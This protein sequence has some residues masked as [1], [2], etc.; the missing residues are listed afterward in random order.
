MIN[1][2]LLCFPLSVV[3]QTYP[4]NDPNRLSASR[5]ARK[6]LPS[7]DPILSRGSSSSRLNDADLALQNLARL[8]ISS[9][10]D[11]FMQYCKFWNCM[12]M[13]V[14]YS[15]CLWSLHVFT[16]TLLYVCIVTAP[17]NWSKGK[18]LGSG[19]FGQVFLC[20]DNDTGGYIACT[21]NCPQHHNGHAIN[22]L[23]F[24]VAEP[25]TVYVDM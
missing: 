21:L 23:C 18:L 24:A 17:T 15:V 22:K 13:A 4:I 16:S 25:F 12:V 7:A 1:V 20:H 2:I 8:N 9:K 11:S 10:G 3:Y 5:P 6:A 19:A 14:E